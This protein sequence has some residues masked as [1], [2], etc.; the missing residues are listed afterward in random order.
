MKPL[1][2][3]KVKNPDLMPFHYRILGGQ[4]LLTNDAGYHAWLS[5]EEFGDFVGGTLD[6]ESQAMENLRSARMVRDE[7]AEIDTIEKINGRS[8]HIFE[9]TSLHIVILTLRCNQNC[10]Y[11]HANRKPKGAKGYDMSMEI[12]EKTLDVIFQ[13]PA[14]ELTIEFQG[15][16]PLLNFEVLRYMV[17]Q[18]Y[19]RAERLG[20]TVYFSLV[21]NLSVLES[22]DVD[23]LVDH[24]V[25]VCS[26]LDGPRKLHD[27]NRPFGKMSSY[28][29]TLESIDS[30][31]GAYNS[32]K[33]DL[34]LAYVNVLA[35]ISRSSLS[36][37]KEIVDEYIHQGHKVVHLRPLNPF[38]MGKKIWAKE[39][40]K[41]EEFLVFWTS[42]MDYMIELNEQGTE[43]MEKMA[44]IMLTRILTD[45][46]PNYMDLRS[47]CGAGIGQLAYNHDGKVYTCD[48]GRMVGAMGDDIFQ[49]GDVSTDSYSDIIHHPG[50]RS[51]CAASCLECLPGCSQCA[52]APYC[53]VC[54]V[55]NYVVQGDLVARMPENDR[56]KIQMGMLDYL[57]L[58]LRKPGIKDLLSRWTET[59]DRSSVYRR[60]V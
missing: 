52:Y 22:D 24:G 31:K 18:G 27:K 33:H 30:F 8:G 58:K 13:S 60:R 2:L 53:G 12:A 15:G 56:C 25:M 34:S 54:P 5:K 45:R 51:L 32:R 40:Y 39:G 14:R 20:K 10:V 19:E 38:G 42:A 11:C 4:V 9:G 36:K 28:D 26:S 55:Y 41:A 7:N 23:F 35:T 59:R 37:P 21:S 49:V 3:P 44:S 46:D 50:V 6:P 47:P 29:S 16:E 43:I 1:I 17:E 48:E 57:F